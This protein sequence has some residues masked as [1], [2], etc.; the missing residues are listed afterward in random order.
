MDDTLK[1]S[2]GELAHVRIEDL[3]RALPPRPRFSLRW[4]LPT[5]SGVLLATLV[6]AAY[7]WRASS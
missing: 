4:L 6:V 5:G 1:A 7:R 2:L 3:R